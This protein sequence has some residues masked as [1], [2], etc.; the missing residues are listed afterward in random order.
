MSELDNAILAQ[1]I[2]VA[3]H[4]AAHEKRMLRNLKDIRD[5]IAQGSHYNPKDDP[6]YEYKPYPKCVRREGFP[7]VVVQNKR[8]M[9]TF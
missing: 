9:T 7:D 8:S 5:E 3:K 2:E 6:P 4:R 1:N